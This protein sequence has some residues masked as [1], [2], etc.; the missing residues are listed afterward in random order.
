MRI[1]VN[2]DDFGFDDDSVDA[3]IECIE[4]GC[5]T[6]ATIMA[7]MPASDR[8]IEF[9]RTRPDVSFGVHLVYGGDGLERPL[10]APYLLPALVGADGAFL[11][12]NTT[13]LKAM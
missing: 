9:A 5:V 6:S 1:I 3:T 11:Q 4:R 8:A 2:A 10:V 13:R 7:N 12:S